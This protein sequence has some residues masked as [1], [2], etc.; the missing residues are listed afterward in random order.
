MRIQSEYHEM[1]GLVLTEAQAKRLW[2]LDDH[3]CTLLLSTLTRRGFLKRTPAGTY[4]R[5]SA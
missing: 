4:I 1:P 2:N 3:T 5:A